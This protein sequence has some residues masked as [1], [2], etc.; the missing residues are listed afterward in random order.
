MNN[1]YDDAIHETHHEYSVGN[2]GVITR[3]IITK[4]IEHAKK[5]EELLDLYRQ[6]R[7]AR[8]D[9]HVGLYTSLALQ[10]E[11]LEEELK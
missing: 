5:V 3:D 2:I 9:K 11:T 7:K 1:I 8:N 10:I 6:Y 4:A